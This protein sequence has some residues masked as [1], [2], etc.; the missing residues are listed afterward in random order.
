MSVLKGFLQPSPMEETKEVIISERF[1]GEDGKPLPF[2]IR[3]IDSE[4]A[5][6]LMKRCRRRERVNGQMVTETD[7]T[8]YSKLLILTCVV[9]P[10]FK[11]SEMCDYYK[12]INPEEENGL[13]S[14]RLL[15]SSSFF[16]FYQIDDTISMAE[17]S[18]QEGWAGKT[19]RKLDLRKKYDINVVAIKKPDGTWKPVKPEDTI[20]SDERL[21]II[22]ER[23]V[24]EAITQ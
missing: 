10:N 8:K 6:A 9:S 13:R 21:L 1:K 19:I 23:G 14:A 7:N 20:H 3:K 17:I 16:D 18:P 24:L 5:S 15:M 22:A 4:T 11:D 2:K 12:V